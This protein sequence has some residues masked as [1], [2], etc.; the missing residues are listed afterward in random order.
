[1]PP[2]PRPPF[3]RS[4]GLL[5]AV[6]LSP[7]SAPWRALTVRWCLGTVGGLAARPGGSQS[8][9]AGQK[10]GERLVDWRRGIGDSVPMLHLPT[11]TKH[12]GYTLTQVERGPSWAIYSKAK[13][14]HH[15]DHFEVIRIRVEPETTFPNGMTC[16]EREVYPNSEAWGDAAWTCR[17]IARAKAI[18]G[19]L[20]EG[21]IG[22]SIRIEFSRLRAECPDTVPA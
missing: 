7:R 21:K 2:K 11:V 22:E 13:P 4:G 8:E 16:P 10:E 12:N 9:A 1:M 18:A 15:N 5:R 3:P 14:G 17:T 6:A 19:L 20:A